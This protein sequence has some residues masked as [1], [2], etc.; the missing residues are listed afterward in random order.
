MRVTVLLLLL[1]CTMT[2]SAQKKNAFYDARNLMKSFDGNQ[3]KA[4]KEVLG[5]LQHHY[6][7]KGDFDPVK[8]A[9]VYKDNPFIAPYL[10]FDAMLGITALDANGAGQRAIGSNSASGASGMALTPTAAVLGLTDFLVRRSKQ[11]L[12]IAFFKEFNN[13]IK[14][15]QEL[16]LIFPQTSK[17][18]EAIESDIY[19]F[20]AF[21]EVLRESFNEDLDLL[22]ANLSNYFEESDRIDD[23]TTKA[24]AS[25]CFEVIAMFKN[26]KAPTDVIRYLGK[27]AMLQV[28][29]AEDSEIKALQNSLK[30][31]TLFSESMEYLDASRY[32]ITPVEFNE[33]LKD[34]VQADLFL[35]IIYQRGKSLKLADKTLGDYM[36][37]LQKNRLAFRFFLNE[38]KKF[39]NTGDQLFKQV[40]NSRRKERSSNRSDAETY[41][42]AERFQDFYLYV[43][44]GLEL[45]EYTY[46]YKKV[47]LGNEAKRDSMFAHYTSI[48]HDVNKLIYDVN[49]KK[50]GVAVIGTIMI[51]EKILPDGQLICEQKLLMKYGSF[52][53]TAMH[54]RTPDEVA[55]AIEAFALPP[56]SSAMKKYA[57]FSISL[58]AYV[59]ASGGLEFLDN[60]NGNPY[61][62]IATPIGVCF[63]FGLQSA[64]SLSLMASVIDI[65][66][67]TAFRFQDPTT[68]P[69]PDFRVE[70]VLAPGGYLIYGVPRF[71]LSLGIGAQMG[72]YL[73]TV[74]NQ[75]GT[76]SAWRMGA[77]VALDIPLVSLYN[78]NKKYKVCR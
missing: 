37:T 75:S 66:A 7:E 15:S 57:R 59:G 8:L 70:N 61:Y 67:L 27:D 44:S 41:S 28:I 63:N 18:M 36:Q 39:V 50:Y 21:W 69:L 5:I 35:G 14:E 54:A 49:L 77:F 56:G 22:P 29:T 25:D 2:S 46:E 10:N 43:K 53:A 13:K 47:M 20:N 1:L 17:V 26:D 73:R 34:S 74:N 24:L 11:E 6:D 52:I 23:L 62:A 78:S 32:W 48:L 19:Q 72:P 55:A 42:D 33:M 58:N 31:S 51:I 4:N 76:A 65:G 30:L 40:Q 60:T 64:G 12:H 38:V 16:R 9:E 3:L 68:N 71:P 45:L